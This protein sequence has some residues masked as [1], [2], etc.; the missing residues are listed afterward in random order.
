LLLFYL[1]KDIKYK[2]TKFVIKELGGNDMIKVYKTQNQES[3]DLTEGTIFLRP[4]E[5]ESIEDFF[6]KINNDYIKKGFNIIEGKIIAVIDGLNINAYNFLSHIEDTNINPSE[7]VE[8]MKE[9]KREID[10]KYGIIQRSD[11][12]F[13]RPIMILQP[14]RGDILEHHV[15]ALVDARNNPEIHYLFTSSHMGIYD[16]DE[17]KQLPDDSVRS[18]IEEMYDATQTIW[19]KLHHKDKFESKVPEIQEFISS[20]P[21]DKQAEFIRRI[22]K[23]IILPNIGYISEDPELHPIEEVLDVISDRS[24]DSVT[25]AEGTIINKALDEDKI[26]K[27][28]TK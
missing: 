25:R 21:K 10:E 4:N 9:A 15:K 17:L 16:A 11:E 6:D 22:A 5:G 23:E 3:D 27:D 28:T 14:F 7:A 1:D 12:Q 2:Y 13:G 8:M 19:Q 20:L 24:M 18:Y 26:I